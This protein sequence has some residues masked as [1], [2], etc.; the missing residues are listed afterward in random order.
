MPPMWY[1]APSALTRS[2]FGPVST[3][4]STCTSRPRCRP[5][6]AASNPIGPAPVTSTCCGS[7]NARRPTRATCSHALATTVVGSEQ[8]AEEPERRVDPHRVLGLD[9]PALGHEAVDLLDAA[10]GVL[11]VAAHV[12]LADGAVRAR[13]GVGPAHDAD[14]QVA[15]LQAAARAGVDDPAERLVAEHQP[16]LARAAPSRTRPRRSRRRCRTRRPPPPRPAPTRRARRA[17]ERPRSGRC[18]ASSARP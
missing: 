11:A 3:R 18:P 17:R 13:D 1:V 10:L 16:V 9:P 15:L 5:S 12:P 14:D 6:S 8:H 4:S 7:Q 2:G